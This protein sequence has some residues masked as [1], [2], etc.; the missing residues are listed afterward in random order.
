[1]N[2]LI[3][4]K[5]VNFFEDDFYKTDNYIAMIDQVSHIVSN[6]VLGLRPSFQKYEDDIAK[7]ILNKLQLSEDYIKY[8]Y[9]VVHCMRVERHT[10][11]A[12]EMHT[13]LFVIQADSESYIFV[14]D[15]TC[16]DIQRG[17]IVSLNN[18]IDHGLNGAIDTPFIAIAFDFPYLVVRS[19][20]T[21]LKMWK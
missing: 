17:D 16:E 8:L 12:P 13:L 10:D 5:K 2:P 9:G 18:K 7:F 14:D 21:K 11:S 19:I 20:L 4:K 3:H 6:D 15:W 1:L